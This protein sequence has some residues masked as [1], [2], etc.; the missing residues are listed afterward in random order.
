MAGPYWCQTGPGSKD[1]VCLF[2]DRITVKSDLFSGSI[3]FDS[4]NKQV[5]SISSFMLAFGVLGFICGLVAVGA[6]LFIAVDQLKAMSP[7]PGSLL[8]II[9]IAASA[10]L[11]F[12]A[13]VGVIAYA[14][15]LPKAQAEDIKKRTGVTCTSEPCKKF[16]G[17]VS[18]GGTRKCKFGGTAA[19][20]F[21]IIAGI[22]QI[23]ALVLVLVTKEAA[24]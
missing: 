18:C 10:A 21:E 1:S 20:A 17:E 12:F 9:F 4:D 14:A 19:F 2:H 11:I 23:A 13:F 5:K 22:F 6:I 15:R 24:A 7:L 3:K 16:S 8:K